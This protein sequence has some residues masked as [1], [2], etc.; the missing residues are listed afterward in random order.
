ML[1]SGHETKTEMVTI[2][3]PVS[4]EFV[5]RCNLHRISV[6]PVGDNDT[7]RIGVNFWAWR[8]KYRNGHEKSSHESCESLDQTIL[9]RISVNIFATTTAFLEIGAGRSTIGIKPRGS[10]VVFPLARA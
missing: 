2:D 4:Y 7:F 10:E 9:H 8:H 6:Q 5:D 1:E 3:V